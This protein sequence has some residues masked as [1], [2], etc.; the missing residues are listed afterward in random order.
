MIFD[1]KTFLVQ[2]N[3]KNDP[4]KELRFRTG[5]ARLE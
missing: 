4:V 2:E 5:R 1:A 3:A